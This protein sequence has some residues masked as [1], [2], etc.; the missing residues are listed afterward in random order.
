MKLQSLALLALAGLGFTPAA[1]AA[2]KY[3][4]AGCGLGSV[5]F[6]TK[7]SQTSAATTNGSFNSQLFGIT[8]GTS[9]CLPD[10]QASALHEQEKFIYANF[11]SLS[12]EM[13]QGRGE[14]LVGLAS[15]LGCESSVQPQFTSFAQSKYQTVF[16]APGA[17]AALETLKEEMKREPVLAQQCK[18]VQL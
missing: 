4:M 5:I 9:N 3:G 8:S 7:G 1:F 10:A 12:K 11:A 14:T 2:R 17:V 13:A 16:A 6:G 18:Y 15:V